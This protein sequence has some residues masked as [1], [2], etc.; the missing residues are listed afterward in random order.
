MKRIMTTIVAAAL[1]AGLGASAAS[2]APPAQNSVASSAGAGQMSGVKALIQDARLQGMKAALKLTP[3]QQ[4]YWDPFESAVRD[5]FT[6]RNEMMRSTRQAIATDNPVQLL[7]TLSDD[8][9]RGAAQMKKVA[10]AAKPLYENLNP[11]QKHAFGPL[12]LTLRGNPMKAA[13]RQQRLQQQ[14]MQ[15]WAQDNNANDGD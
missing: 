12:L 6:Q 3:D 7:D 5:S 15:R 11:S 14:L 4:K 2:A 10:D 13:G 8:A 9:S 1:A